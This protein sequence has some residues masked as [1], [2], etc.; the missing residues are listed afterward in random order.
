VEG[1]RARFG[2]VKMG[3]VWDRVAD[4]L[5]VEIVFSDDDLARVRVSPRLELVSEVIGA[6]HCRSSQL[7]PSL[8]NWRQQTAE[9]LG[10]IGAQVLRDL[11]SGTFVIRG[12][13]ADADIDTDTGF[14][15]RLE[16][17]LSRP[18]REWANL[19]ELRSWGIPVQPG[20]AEGRPDALSTLSGAARLFHDSAVGPYW[21]QMSSAAVAPALAWMHTM[22]TRGLEAFLNSLHPD[23]TW[24]RPTLTIIPDWSHCPPRCPH[25]ALVARF[26]HDG[27]VRMGVSRQG[28]TIIP[29]VLSSILTAWTDDRDGPFATIRLLLVPV[30]LAPQIF[31]DAAA[32]QP[33]PLADLLGVTRARVLRAC[34]QGPQTTTASALTL[35]ISNSS[36]SEHATVLRAAGLLTSHRTAN[37]VEHHATPIGTALTQRR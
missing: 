22:S 2:I 33:D 32:D 14:A 28:L 20:L 21:D 19:L 6:A 27:I 5:R 29:T 15:D 37:R 7:H 13:M 11:R 36:A 18:T 12:M 9:A 3:A 10:P 24:H 30:T 25:R 1:F 16:T 31:Q 17:S 35:G 4:R 8:H 26:Q 34:V 23:I